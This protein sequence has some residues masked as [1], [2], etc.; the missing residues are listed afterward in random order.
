MTPKKPTLPQSPKA[1]LLARLE[2]YIGGYM[3]L[4]NPLWATILSLYVVLT[5]TYQVFDAVPYLVITA[6]TKQSGKTRLMELLA[7]LSNHAHSFSAMTPAV[8]F[9]LLGQAAANNHGASVFFDEAET[10]SSEAAST[11]RSVLNVG[12]RRG[13]TIPRVVKN[14]VVEFPVYGPK[15]F[16]LIGDV[17][18]TLRDRSIVLTLERGTPVKPYSYAQAHA[19]AMALRPAIEREAW[20]RG[21]IVVPDVFVGGREAEI[22]APILSLASIWCPEKLDAIIM[23][24]SDLAAAKTAPKRRYIDAGN[25]EA[26]AKDSEYSE[27]ALRDVAS[28]LGDRKHMPSANIVGRLRELPAAPWRVYR[29]EGITPISLANLLSRYGV[30]PKNLKIAGKVTRGYARESVTTALS[31]LGGK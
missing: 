29:G 30:Q 6:A 15:V 26:E 25:A 23:A 4:P 2:A 20:Y 27:R 11:M 31:T 24:A 9:R 12:Y 16:V 8:L 13:Q 5:W 19:E 3:A 10:L 28:V 7:F 18:D 22:W 1:E 14:E 17:Y 21:D